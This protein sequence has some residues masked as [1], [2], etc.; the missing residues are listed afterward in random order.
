MANERDQKRRPQRDPT[1][2]GI[3]DIPPERM[4]ELVR[5]YA[6]IQRYQIENG[7]DDQGDPPPD[8]E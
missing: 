5:H 6:E 1:R 8:E 4:R 2:L 3:D 7:L